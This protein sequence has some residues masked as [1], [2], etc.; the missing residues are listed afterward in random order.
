MQDLVWRREA[1]VVVLMLMLM[2]ML[3]LIVVMAVVRFSWRK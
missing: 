1:L 2:L 3:M